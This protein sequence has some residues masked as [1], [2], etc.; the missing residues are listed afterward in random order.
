MPYKDPEKE[1]LYS[2]SPARRAAKARYSSALTRGARA[3]RRM[4]RGMSPDRYRQVCALLTAEEVATLD[5]FA[6]QVPNG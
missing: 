2:A 1:R 3:L 5:A 6:F 4:I